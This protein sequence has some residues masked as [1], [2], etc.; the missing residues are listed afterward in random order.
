M[1]SLESKV[2][3]AAGVINVILDN[4]ELAGLVGKTISQ[5]FFMRHEFTDEQKAQ[6]DAHFDDLSAR[7]A[8][9]HDEI[10]NQ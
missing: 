3:V 6:L 4:K 10:A 7:E 1:N 9:L 8:R 2:K 5:F